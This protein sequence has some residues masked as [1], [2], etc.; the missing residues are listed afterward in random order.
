MK[1]YPP[2][3]VTPYGAML[4]MERVDPLVIY[5]NYDETIQWSI[6]GGMAPHPM[7]QEGAYLVDGV[8]GLHPP[9]TFVEH[10]GA[11]QHGVTKQHTVFD[12]AEFDMQIEF[13]VPPNVT[14]H[15]EAA[16][17][18]RRV[19]REWMASWDP[20]KAGTLE[21]VTP[22]MGRWTC[23]PRLFR[24]PPDRQFKAQA[25]RLR[26]RYTW[27]IRNDDAF[28]RGVDSVSEFRVL[29]SQTAVMRDLFNR[30]DVGTLGPQYQQTYTG[31]G[32][33]TCETDNG[34][35]RWFPSGTSERTV[36]NRVLGFNEV[37]TV[38][39]VGAF[40]GGTWTYTVNGQTTAGIAHNASAA[41][42][43]TAIVALSNVAPGDVTVT[44]ANGGPYLVTFLAAL[45]LQNVTSSASGASLTP[46]GTAAAVQV[47]TTV[48]GRG[49]NTTGDNQIISVKLGEPHQTP[50]PAN[51][52]IDL[53]GRHNGN[54][55]TPTCVHARIGAGTVVLTRINAGVEVLIKSE[56]F[57]V[58]P[59]WWEDWSLI[60]GTPTSARHFKVRRG[61]SDELNFKETGTGSAL[62]ASNRG[63]AWGMKA[64]AGG[65]VQQV[66]P[67]IEEFSVGE[68]TTV[69]TTSGHMSLTNFGDQDGYPRYLVYGPG[70]F[71][72]SNNPD[73]AHTISFGPLADNQI[74]L[75]TTLPRLRGVVDLSPEQ[76]EQFDEVSNLFT[77]FLRRLISL[78]SS[79]NT[80]PLLEWFE[81]LLGIR[82]PQG[83]LYRL[84]QGRFTEP[85]PPKPAGEPPTTA[86]IAIEIRNGNA[87]SKV[88]AALTPLR[89]WPE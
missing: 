25:R 6:A 30:D 71:R 2:G 72:F 15:N 44:G 65:S 21:W 10:K 29:S 19:I 45:G 40:T 57:D 39:I 76:P 80:P 46:G 56:T 28:W 47:A 67:S 54:D 77:D 38:S 42:F 59:T 69:A 70:T 8:S 49:P 31:A 51:G 64:G 43:Q 9:F 4:L 68:N 75:L 55:A 33:G 53:Y 41:T 7:V 1:F 60:C 62:G 86:S 12:P 48:D 26:Q 78:A 34:R 13:T 66:P 24:A 14:D 82:P 83:E 5:T 89:R 16:K 52:F 20:D 84:L 23:N 73:T 63:S 88:V 87:D 3:E 36:V 22:D 74:A 37:Q 11:R 17:A 35:A 50:F 61:G 18:I 32:A 58:T 79:G 27:T 85:I 81:S